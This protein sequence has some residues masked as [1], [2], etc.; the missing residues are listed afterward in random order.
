VQNT[1]KVDPAIKNRKDLMKSINPSESAMHYTN[2]HSSS[3]GGF[4][5]AARIAAA[6][7]STRKIISRRE[8]SKEQRM[9]GRTQE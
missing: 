3:S 9:E 6:R 5:Q 7:K 4:I 8:F 1:D 2:S